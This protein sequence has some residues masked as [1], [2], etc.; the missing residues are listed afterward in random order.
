M[1]THGDIIAA[2]L[3]LE[4]LAWHPSGASEAAG[5]NCIGL[6]VIIAAR[7]GLRR[8]EAAFTPYVGMA[9]PPERKALA[10]ALREHMEH[11]APAA[12]EPGDLLLVKIRGRDPSD[13][14]LTHVVLMLEAGE[15]LESLCLDRKRRTGRVL[16]RLNPYAVHSAWRVPGIG[17]DPAPPA[18]P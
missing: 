14:E 2:A 3:P 18:G 11:V 1:I 4:G 17:S 6:M 10:R 9:A 5:C 15:I 8:L 13:P 12:A 7:L 16:R